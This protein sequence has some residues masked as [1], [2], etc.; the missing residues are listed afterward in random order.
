MIVLF[1]FATMQAPAQTIP[2]W[3]Q[4]VHYTIEATLDEDAEQLRGAGTLV[5]Q[6]NSPHD[7]NEVFFQLNLNAF[8]PNS[9]WATT[10][11][12]PHLNFQRLDEPDFAFARIQSLTLD[13]QP[14][15]A[16]FPHS[17]DST[18]VRYALPRPLTAGAAATFSFTWEARPS[19]LCRRQCRDGRSYDFAQWYPRIAPFDANGWQ[20]PSL[21]ST[22]R[23]LR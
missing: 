19:T 14:L 18:V 16:D 3:Q 1:L 8:R 15:L 23:V 7:L 6:N 13:D 12:R 5:Y 17:P 10:E 9:V 22:R 20:P 11:E 2:Y 21:V 4:E